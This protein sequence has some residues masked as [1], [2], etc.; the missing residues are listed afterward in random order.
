MPTVYYDDP[1]PPQAHFDD[2]LKIPAVSNDAH[3]SSFTNFIDS[4]NLKAFAGLR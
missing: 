1:K 3:E 2:F 4:N